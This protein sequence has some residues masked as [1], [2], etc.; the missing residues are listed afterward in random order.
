[1]TILDDDKIEIS[2]RDYCKFVDDLNL[3]SF[4]VSTEIV[5]S[6]YHLDAMKSYKSNIDKTID[7]LG[8]TAFVK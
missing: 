3:I 2:G 4:L 6:E 8:R 1:M 5:R 7:F